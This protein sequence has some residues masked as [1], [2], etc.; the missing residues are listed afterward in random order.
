MVA[1]RATV[2][3]LKICALISTRTSMALLSTVR[4]LS[5]SDLC[6]RDRS[7]RDESRD[8]S[9]ATEGGCVGEVIGMLRLP[10]RTFLSTEAWG[11]VRPG[12]HQHDTRCD[13]YSDI[14][15]KLLFPISADQYI[16]F[17]NGQV[18]PVQ[19][20]SKLLFISSKP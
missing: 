13:L 1:Y 6:S 2:H 15:V 4:L 9:S 16:R 19:I 14:D 5:M 3:T 12:H 20:E 17:C 10:S 8:A 11:K 7:V 18:L